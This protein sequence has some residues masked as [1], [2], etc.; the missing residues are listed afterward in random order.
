MS[1]EQL[2]LSDEVI[3]QIA[4]LLQLAILSGTDVVDHLR[5]MRVVNDEDDGSSLVL[6][7]EYRQI[8]EDQIKSML[9][10]VG[11]PESE[12]VS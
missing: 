8:S 3:S 2:R 4:K 1:K 12:D 10:Q 5:L 11:Q 7:N 9:D 6:S